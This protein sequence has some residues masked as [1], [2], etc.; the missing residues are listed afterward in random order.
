MTLDHNSVILANDQ[1]RLT[2]NDGTIL[3]SRSMASS[4]HTINRHILVEERKY[5]SSTRSRTPV[6]HK[7][8]D[9]REQTDKLDA[10]AL[11]TGVCGVADQLRGGTGSFD[12]GEDRVAFGAERER[13]ESGADVGYDAGDDDLLFTGGFNSGAEIWI[14]PGADDFQLRSFQRTVW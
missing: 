6:A 13:E 10:S 5:L 14:V 3:D 1:A 8:A 7:I 9:D 2:R 4:K 12:V 11:H